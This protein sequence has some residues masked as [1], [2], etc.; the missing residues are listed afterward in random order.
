[1]NPKPL[2]VVLD[3]SGYLA[4]LGDIATSFYYIVV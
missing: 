4:A 1:L 2:E 3:I